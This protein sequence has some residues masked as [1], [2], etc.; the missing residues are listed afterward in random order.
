MQALLLSKVILISNYD[1]KV[2][3]QKCF[4]SLHYYYHDHY[5]IKL[6]FSEVLISFILRLI[7]TLT[8]VSEGAASKA[9][10]NSIQPACRSFVIG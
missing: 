8:R 6:L 7:L 10:Q 1:K 2:Q 5:N 4:L 3:S 9:L